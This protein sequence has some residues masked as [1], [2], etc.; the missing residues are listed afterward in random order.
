MLKKAATKKFRL[1]I[2]AYS[3]GEYL[4]I[5]T[6]NGLTLKHRTCVINQSDDDFLDRD[7][8]NM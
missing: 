5:L 2:W 8:N 4:Y 6:K 3:H 7:L 1:R